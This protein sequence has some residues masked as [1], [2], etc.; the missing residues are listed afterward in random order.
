[1]PSLVWG[2]FRL[3]C[4]CF[5]LF[6]IVCFLILILI[7]FVLVMA[8]MLV[9]WVL[10]VVELFIWGD[11]DDDLCVDVVLFACCLVG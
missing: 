10:F 8:G 5:C 2:L 1:M 11:L 4:C 3:F 7:V 9:L 6:L